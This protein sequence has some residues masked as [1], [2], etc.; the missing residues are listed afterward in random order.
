MKAFREVG[1]DGPVI[2]EVSGTVEDHKRTAQKMR[3]IIAM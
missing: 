2:H 1:Y 3:E